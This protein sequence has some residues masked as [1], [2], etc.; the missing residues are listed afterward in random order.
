MKNI[1][2]VLPA[3]LILSCSKGNQSDS[4][5]SNTS[6]G[7]GGSLAR[8]AL[9]A[10]HLYTVTP[11][12][13]VA[14][15]VSAAENPVR[16]SSIK[17]GF[18]VETIFPYK[19]NLFIGTETGMKIMGLSIPESPNLLADFQHIRSC[20]PVV[21]N[22]NYAFVTLRID[23][24]CTRGVNEL[25]IIDI[26]NLKQPKLIKIYPLTKPYGLAIDGNNL[27]VCDGGIKHYNATDV[28]NLTLKSKL[29]I[30]ATDVI[31]NNGILMVIGSDGIYQYDYSGGTLVFLSKIPTT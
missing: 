3:L 14:Y 28:M 30:E 18:G 2:F 17:L 13:L 16:Q 22:D 27:F 29:I 8:F 23:A 11:S 19:N 15:N 25:Q 5:T 6:T 4:S 9:S 10:D 26:K 21:A 12:S 7:V 1:Y 31:A 24:A 20:D